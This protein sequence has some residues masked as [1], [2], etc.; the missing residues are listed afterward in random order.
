MLTTD[1]IPASDPQSRHLMVVLH[2]LG[3][4]M[5]G[6]RWLPPMLGLPWMNY[7]L[8][9]APEPHFDGFSWFGIC[10]EGPQKGAVPAEVDRSRQ[11]LFEVLDAQHVAGFA[12]EKM[13]LFGF[14]QGCLMTWETALFYPHALAGLVGISGWPH[15]PHTRAWSPVARSQQ[16]LVSH[17]M[18]DPLIPF[19]AVRAAVAALREAGMGVEWREFAK[20]HTIAGE[21]EL[22]VIREFLRERAGRAG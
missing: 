19:A 18:H 4:S 20:V 8:V 22:R 16:L 2:G 12:R 6:Y 3:D 9:N 21:E 1:F 5:D 17:G 11:Q 13:F 15:D 14:S 7:L 10:W